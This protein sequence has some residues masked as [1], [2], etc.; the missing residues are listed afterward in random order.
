MLIEKTTKTIINN[1]AIVQLH[2]LQ[3][4][5]VVVSVPNLEKEV[6]LLLQYRIGQKEYV[7]FRKDP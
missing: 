2:P 1:V 4:T 3:E 7:K 5:Y 6:V